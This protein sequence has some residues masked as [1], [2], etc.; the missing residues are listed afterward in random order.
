MNITTTI[1]KDHKIEIRDD[2][3]DEDC[4]KLGHFVTFPDGSVQCAPISPYDCRTVDLVA[5][6]IDLGAPDYNDL[7]SSGINGNLSSNDIRRLWDEK[8]GEGSPFPKI[9]K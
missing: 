8:Y 3:G 7:K 6:W 9:N 5:A 2:L 1:Y 4:I